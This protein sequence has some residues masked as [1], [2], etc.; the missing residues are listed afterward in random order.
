MTGNKHDSVGAG[1]YNLHLGKKWEMIMMKKYNLIKARK[2]LLPLTQL[3]KDY[4]LNSQK[5]KF[6]I[7][8][9]TK[10]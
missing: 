10:T 7:M 2:N 9:K 1:Q 3:E 6:N 4:L 5:Q 8:Q